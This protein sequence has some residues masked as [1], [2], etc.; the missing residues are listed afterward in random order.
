MG[1]GIW[2]GGR[3]WV[4][5]F[6]VARPR[7]EK[8]YRERLTIGDRYCISF[9]SGH[10]RGRPGERACES[11]ASGRVC[12]RA[13]ACACKQTLGAL[14]PLCFPLLGR[15]LVS[16]LT[17]PSSLSAA[18]A[19]SHLGAPGVKRITRHCYCKCWKRGAV[20]LGYMQRTPSQ[21]PGW[22][23]CPAC[24]CTTKEAAGKAIQSSPRPFRKTWANRE[25]KTLNCAGEGP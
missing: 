19:F 11:N 17:P 6:N 25:G 23:V 13:R 5:A 16:A 1:L 12:S 15:K 18:E 8:T 4:R 24:L 20:C 9:L 3:I 21:I 22:D 2:G 10:R 14:R 7:L